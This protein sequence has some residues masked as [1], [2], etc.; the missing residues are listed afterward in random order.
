VGLGVS[1]AS[2]RIAGRRS[3]GAMV[4]GYWCG[5]GLW[6]CGERGKVS[7]FTLDWVPLGPCGDRCPRLVSSYR[8][9]LSCLVLLGSG[10]GSTPLLHELAIQIGH[11]Q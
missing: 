11:A 10:R 1:V 7:F 6:V 9:L 4:S 2:P 8:F 5:A 3:V